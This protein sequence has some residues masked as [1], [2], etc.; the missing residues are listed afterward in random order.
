MGENLLL[1]VGYARKCQEGRKEKINLK[2]KKNPVPLVSISL[3]DG[4]MGIME[5]Q[6]WSQSEL[7]STPDSSSYQ[8]CD[9]KQVH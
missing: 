4:R 3:T 9:L 8:L 1:P 7:G 6:T 5:G 2:K